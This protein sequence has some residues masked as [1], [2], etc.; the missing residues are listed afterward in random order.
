V[1]AHLATSVLP[2]VNPLLKQ[3]AC[4]FP[5]EMLLSVVTSTSLLV[6][7]HHLGA[8][9]EWQVA[10]AA[11]SQW[12]QPMPSSRDL[13]MLK[14]VHLSHPLATS[15]FPVAPARLVLLDLCLCTAAPVPA[16]LAPMCLFVAALLLALA[17]WHLCLAVLVLLAA[18]WLFRAVLVRPALAALWCWAWVQ[19]L[20]LQW[21]ALCQSAP[22]HPLA[23]VTAVLCPW[24]AVLA[25]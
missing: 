21:A 11:A 10:K 13:S 9:C 1:Q 25:Q 14:L 6:Q 20:A 12:T 8:V 15:S 7:A 24:Q 18:M 3:E 16:M 2:L 4:T 17:A 5:V 23:V 19:D 22:D